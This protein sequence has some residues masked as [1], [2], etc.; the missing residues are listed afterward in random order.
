[1]CWKQLA[2][3]RVL[4]EVLYALTLL[5]ASLWLWAFAGLARE[6]QSS[7]GK[8]KH[9]THKSGNTF[10]DEYLISSNRAKVAHLNKSLCKRECEHS[11]KTVL[12]AVK[13]GHS[14]KLTPANE[15]SGSTF[16]EE[17]CQFC[18]WC[19]VHQLCYMSTCTENTFP[20][21]L[22]ILLWK[23]TGLVPEET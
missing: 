9:S 21:R 12:H 13:A 4:G 15:A 1:M 10:W 20:I 8:R 23:N 2:A 3:R 6:I 22:H 19:H 17:G 16:S 14:S 7:K 18:L 11:S 5:S